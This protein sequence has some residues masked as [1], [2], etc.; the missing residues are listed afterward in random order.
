MYLAIYHSIFLADTFA[1]PRCTVCTA[2]DARR[3]FAREAG[4]FLS[5]ITAGADRF[6][7]IACRCGVRSISLSNAKRGRR[8][9]YPRQRTNAE[10]VV[11]TV[12]RGG[13]RGSLGM[14][15]FRPCN[16]SRPTRVPLCGTAPVRRRVLGVPVESSEADPLRLGLSWVESFPLSAQSNRPSLSPLVRSR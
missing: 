11:R 2:T 4:F 10:S 6:G 1:R 7:L 16:A 14:S 3:I 15:G 8:R 12:A 9:G 13:E 5:A